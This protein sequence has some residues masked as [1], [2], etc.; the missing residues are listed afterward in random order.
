MSNRKVERAAALLETGAQRIRDG[1]LV[2]ARLLCEEALQLAPRNPDA[3]HLLGVIA[4][5]GGQHAMAVE[6]L[7]AAVA[8]RPDDPAFLVNLAY[9]YVGL[10][11]LPEAQAAF[12]RAARLEPRDPELQ[13]GI[14][15]CLAMQ[16]KVREAE[17]VLRRLV[18]QHPQYALGWFNLANALKDQER[19]QEA[20]ERYERATQLAPRNAE[21][22]CNL[23]IAL[24]KLGRYEE[25][26]QAFR[27]CL[28]VNPAFVPAYP[29]L[30]VT[31]NSLRRH[32]E[33]EAMCRE[34]L[35]RDPGYRSAWPILGKA[36]T[37]Q[38][39]W[40]DALEIQQRAV[41]EFPESPDA[42]GDFGNALANVGRIEEALE[43]FD[44]A[45]ALGN[46]SSLVH[47]FKAATLFSIGRLAEGAKAFVGRNE[48]SQFLVRHPHASLSSALPA[49]L[50]GRTVCLV[51]EQ[52]IGDEIFFLRYV[53][54][55]RR[56]G[57]RIQY[58]G[59]PK[60]VNLLSRRAL[61]DDL[62]ASH[63][64]FAGADHNALLGDLPDLLNNGEETALPSEFQ[65]RSGAGK[66]AAGFPARYRV[67]W[68]EVP[69]PLPLQPLQ[70]R[71]AAITEKLRR[72]GPPPYRS[73]TWRAGTGPQEQRGQVWFLFKAI[74]LEELAEPLRG[75]SGTF[76]A[77]QRRPQPGEVERLASLLGQPVHDLSAANEDLE[78]MLALLEI[79]DDYI[80]VSNTNM[81]LR[82]SVGRTARVLQPWPPDWRWMAVGSASPWYPGFRVYRQERDGS[83]ARALTALR[84]D[85]RADQRA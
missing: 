58:Y 24:H 82:A 47:L 53:A 34:A 48:R 65:P 30:A 4:L 36:L 72:L 74:A 3:L 19:Y 26:E 40:R 49:D 22:Q 70:D 20:L 15:N 31:L 64:P 41:R 28:A 32:E 66:R 80:G 63:E 5:Q 55:L 60:I 79:V 6:K 38:G 29:A 84:E 83:W 37:G 69:P 56:R 16:G 35:R 68:P 42:L 23:A 7:R 10:Q 61:L 1:Q 67:Y 18:E 8:G 9:G 73:L 45:C 33:S 77:L 54:P 11:R 25:A 50:R 17:A 78:D 85:L 75:A 13:L 27:T 14:G 71:V 21:A 12:E 57:C 81:H 76:I 59:S 43:S 62:R 2:Q 39:R 44:R 51:G 46:V 52:G